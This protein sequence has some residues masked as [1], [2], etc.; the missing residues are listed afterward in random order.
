MEDDL[1]IKKNYKMLDLEIILKLH[2]PS[3]QKN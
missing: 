1:A 2:S 3:G